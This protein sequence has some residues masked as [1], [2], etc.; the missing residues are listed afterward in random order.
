MDFSS[1]CQMLLQ[2][3]R[4]K[5]PDWD[6][7]RYL[8]ISS[9]NIWLNPSNYEDPFPLFQCERIQLN[10]ILQCTDFE[11]LS[12]D[13]ISFVDILARTELHDGKTVFVNTG[14]G[15]SYKIEDDVLLVDKGEGIW[16]E[17]V[18]MD[19]NCLANLKERTWYV[20]KAGV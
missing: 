4:I 3:A 2:G 19:N 1:A 7:D 8:Y 9:N 14:L 5:R 16:E 18:Y 13:R 10:R 17:S 11:V 6:E 15:F 20:K 12:S